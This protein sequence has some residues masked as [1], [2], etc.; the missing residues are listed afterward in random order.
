MPSVGA[1]SRRA[2]VHSRTLAR[3]SLLGHSRRYPL[4]RCGRLWDVATFLLLRQ[5]A[6]VLGQRCLLLLYLIF[7][8]I[9]GRR[10]LLW[11]KSEASRTGSLERESTFLEQD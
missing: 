4:W 6:I 5:P 7:Y 11:I 10:E 2:Q 1:S 3:I 8:Q 9:V